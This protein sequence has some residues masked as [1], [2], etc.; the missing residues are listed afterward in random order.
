MPKKELE[1]TTRVHLWL[2]A[3]D[4]EDLTMIYGPTMGPS[5]AIRTIVRNF[6]TG[7]RSRVDAVEHKLGEIPIDSIPQPEELNPD[8]H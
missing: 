3:K 6:L 4:W 8:E 2:F 1:P 7:I 5:K